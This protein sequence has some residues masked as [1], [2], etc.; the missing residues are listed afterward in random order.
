MVSAYLFRLPTCPG[1][2]LALS[3]AGIA[4]LGLMTMARFYIVL[5][6]STCSTW[7]R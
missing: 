7:P 4:S 6:T 2:A 1:T 5:Y 3:C